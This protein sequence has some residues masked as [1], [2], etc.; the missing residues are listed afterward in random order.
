MANKKKEDVV[1][2]FLYEFEPYG[3]LKT[4]QQ[5]FIRAAFNL[6]Y[7]TIVSAVKVSGVSRTAVY[8]WLTEGRPD[9]EPRFKEVLDQ[10]L[11]Y[12]QGERLEEENELKAKIKKKSLQKLHDVIEAIEPKDISKPESPVLIFANKALNGLSETTNTNAK[13]QA[14]VTTEPITGME[15]T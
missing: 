2:T 8:N 6:D 10:V 1:E 13:I 9:Y 14:Q 15:I 5:D 11:L 3:D 7:Y 4:T 12:R